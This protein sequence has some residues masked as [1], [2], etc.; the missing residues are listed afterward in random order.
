[1]FIFIIEIN[2]I[3][4]FNMLKLLWLFHIFLN[5]DHKMYISLC[6]CRTLLKIRKVSH[7]INYLNFFAITNIDG[8][9]G[10]QGPM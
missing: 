6:F 1:M 8:Y 7:W 10:I 3:L 9:G 4:I 5:K 2:N